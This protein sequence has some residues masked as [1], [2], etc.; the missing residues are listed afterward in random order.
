L[1][2]RERGVR[3]RKQLPPL[4]EEGIL[5]WADAH[6]QRTGSWPKRTSGPVVDAPG[7][8]WSG[9]E[10]ALSHGI[11]HLPGGSS[12]TRLLVERRGLAHP[13]ERTQLNRAQIL[14]WAD[15]WHE[16]TG[17]W[18]TTRSGRIPDSDG[19][20]WRGVDKA[21]RYGRRGVDGGSSLAQLLVAERGLR[22]PQLLPP[23]TRKLILAWADAHYERTGKWPHTHSGAIPEAPPETWQGIDSALLNGA[24]RLQRSSLAR[25]LA[26]YR[27]KRSRVTVPPLTEAGILAWCDAH[28]QRSGKWPN[29]AS[30]PVVDAPGENWRTI[31]GALRVGSRRLPGGSSLVQLLVKNRGMR[32]PRRL[33][34]LT[35]ELILYWAELHFQRTGKWPGHKS[36]PIWGGGG[37]TW[38]QVDN[39]LRLGK[40][41]LPGGSSLAKFLANQRT[42]VPHPAMTAPPGANTAPAAR[43]NARRKRRRGRRRR[44]SS[45]KRCGA[46]PIEY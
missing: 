18:P 1:L 10:V 31:D 7:E 41:M 33:P 42:A 37:E 21:L 34:H 29:V 16:R 26:R 32:H 13:H 4:T 39:A 28:F 2:A 20:T 36:G 35:E 17:Q 14:A 5:A 27:G 22:H 12:L 30:G 24:R 3:N 40:R 43:P 23:L 46:V 8:T 9:I 6:V 15:A 25:L 45:S 11:R 19:I 38:S 44:R